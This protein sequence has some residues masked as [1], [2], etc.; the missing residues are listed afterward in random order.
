MLSFF[1]MIILLLDPNLPNLASPDGVGQ[2][3]D[4]LVLTDFADFFFLILFPHHAIKAPLLS[5]FIY[6]LL[7]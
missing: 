4:V 5:L 6:I 2:K 1:R 7:I 3:N